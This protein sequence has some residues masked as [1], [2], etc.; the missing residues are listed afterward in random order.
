MKANPNGITYEAKKVPPPIIMTI[1]TK[2]NKLFH[3][4]IENGADIN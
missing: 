4:L 3:I 2:N 1:S